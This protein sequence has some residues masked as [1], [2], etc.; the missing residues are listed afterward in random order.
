MLNRWA[1][2]HL[3]LFHLFHALTLP[4]EGLSAVFSGLN[5][6]LMCLDANQLQLLVKARHTGDVER[7]R[8]VDARWL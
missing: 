2:E 4:T 7:R 8:D 1:A 5:L 3:T 6:G